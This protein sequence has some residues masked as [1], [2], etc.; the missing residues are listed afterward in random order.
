MIVVQRKVSHL[1]VGDDPCA[2]RSGIS[3]RKVIVVRTAGCKM[4]PTLALPRTQL[5]D[6][7]RLQ[8]LLVIATGRLIYYRPAPRR[9]MQEGRT[10]NGVDLVLSQ[11]IVL[12][13]Q[14]QT[15][16]R[17]SLV[18]SV[19]KGDICRIQNNHNRHGR[20]NRHNALLIR[21]RNPSNLS[22]Q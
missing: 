5:L 6:V 2:E 15:L 20:R 11:T 4:Q 3:E 19:L 9:A 22:L 13:R 18:V 21:Q 17:E 10:E 14:K 1:I 16:A 12:C 7:A 8:A